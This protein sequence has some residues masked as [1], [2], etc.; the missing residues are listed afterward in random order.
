MGHHHYIY[1]YVGMIVGSITGALN[2][3]GDIWSTAIH[4]AVGAAVSFV[5]V[6]I[7]RFIWNSAI[8]FK[9]WLKSR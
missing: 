9:K 1:E 2:N 6:K 5:I 8:Q 3:C 7:C 4:A